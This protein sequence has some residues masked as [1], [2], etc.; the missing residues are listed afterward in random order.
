MTVTAVHPLPGT[1]RADL[2]RY[3][4]SVEQASEHAVA[5]AVVALAQAEPL[6]LTPPDDFAAL[7]GLGARGT[8]DGREV[9]VG[10]ATLF[11]EIPAAVA[12]W[13][14]EQERSGRTTIGVSWDGEIRGALRAEPGATEVRT[15]AAYVEAPGGRLDIVADFGGERILLR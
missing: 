5:A 14:G 3:A 1:T 8:V 6:A 9:T 4:A 7:P 13:C 12:A 2:L 10:R 15:L 11:A